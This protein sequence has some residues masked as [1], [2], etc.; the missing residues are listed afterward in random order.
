[1]QRVY[2]RIIGGP[3]PGDIYL[4]IDDPMPCPTQ[5]VGHGGTRGVP[6]VGNRVVLPY[7][8]LGRGHLTLGIP[9]NHIYLAIV[10]F[11]HREGAPFGH[12]S[13]R[14]PRSRRQIIDAV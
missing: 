10:I 6:G 3:A 7:L 2:Y 13:A 8:G 11:T 12:G 9:T 5:R 4:A 1:M 14:V